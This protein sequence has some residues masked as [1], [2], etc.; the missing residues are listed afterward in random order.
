VKSSS[1]ALTE[2]VKD[3]GVI[4]LRGEGCSGALIERLKGVVVL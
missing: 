3:V 2:G 1:G 4:Y